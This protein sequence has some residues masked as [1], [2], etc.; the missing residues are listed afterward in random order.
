MQNQGEIFILILFKNF[1]RW[2]ILNEGK[3]KYFNIGRLR[4]MIYSSTYRIGLEDI[5]MQNTVTNRVILKIMEDVASFH[6]SAVGRGVFELEETQS[7]W[8][9]L[10][11]KVKVLKRPQYN[12]EVKVET[13]SRGIEKLFAYRDFQLKDT[14][15]NILAIGTSRWIL[16]DLEKRRPMRLTAEMDTLYASEPDK[17]VFDE[18]METIKVEDYIFEKEY[19]VQRRDIDINEHMHNLTYLDMAYETLPEE[20][21]KN[22]IFDNIRVMYKKEIVY[23]EKV[24][25]AYSQNEDKHIITIKSQDTINAIIALY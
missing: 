3:Y 18:A 21:Y 11:W 16:V 23:G 17:S 4:F 5:G 6:S 9:I 10:D 25:C 8:M 19:K 22:H 12:D 7:A 13:W 15:G 1:E 20:V 2:D 14:L 24:Y